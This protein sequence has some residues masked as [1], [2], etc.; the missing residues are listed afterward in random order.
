M[1]RVLFVDDEQSIL[2][3]LQDLLRRQRKVWDMHFACGADKALGELEKTPFDVV[4][5]DMRMPGMDGAALLE[6]VKTRYSG[7]SR[8]VLSGHAEK[9]A[10][11]RALSVAHQYLS[12]PCALDSLRNV[13]ER[14]HRLNELLHDDSVRRIVV[15]LDRLPSVPSTYTNLVSAADRPETAIS[16]LVGI[17]EA[18]PAICAKLLQ[19]VNSAYFAPSHPIVSVSQAVSHLGVEALR[20]LT[21]TA[22]VFATMEGTGADRS[23]LEKIQR[24]S[25]MTARLA[26]S[27]AEDGPERD[28]AFTAGLVHDVGMLVVSMAHPGALVEMEREAHASG[29]PFHEVE[30]DRLGVTHAEV[31]AY[32]LG[33]WGLPWSMVE[34]V[35]YHHHPSSIGSEPRRIL[36]FV[37]AADTL[38]DAIS[39]GNLDEAVRDLDLAF[40]TDAGFAHRLP[41]WRARIQ[42]QLDS[43]PDTN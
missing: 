31:G 12:K 30:N 43:A 23:E 1:I 24:H 35:A 21:L 7:A 3:G 8:I 22:G 16:D 14:T 38:G 33:V 29:R 41:E 5:T 17:V 2:D 6:Q 34:T 26:G 4:V 13:V 20:A 32:L 27:L 18:D 39:S 15:K 37:H 28:E 42:K 9:E 10:V 40:L 19:L 25:F 36:A 11:L